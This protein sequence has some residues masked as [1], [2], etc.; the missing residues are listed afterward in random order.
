MAA[1]PIDNLAQ[2]AVSVTCAKLAIGV[3]GIEIILGRGSKAPKHSVNLKNHLH[4][5]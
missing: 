2:V 3:V 5:A 4:R 1:T